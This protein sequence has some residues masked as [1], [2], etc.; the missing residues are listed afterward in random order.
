MVVGIER[1]WYHSKFNSMNMHYLEFRMQASFF[2]V[3]FPS[4]RKIDYMEIVCLKFIVLSLY[5]LKKN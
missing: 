5:I 1:I 3:F 4:L 2:V